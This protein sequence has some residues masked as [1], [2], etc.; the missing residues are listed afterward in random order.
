MSMTIERH[1]SRPRMSQ[2]VIHNG[3]VHLAGQ[4][5][6]D[7]TA[8]VA[9]QTR[10]TL[11]EIDRL[12][13]LAGTDK[14]KLITALVWLADMRDYD[15]MNEVWDAWTA[16]GCA[17]ARACTEAKLAPGWIVEIMVTAAVE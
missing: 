17:P 2:V 12:L 10:Q 5:G 8:S 9:D 15:A 13:A 11:E 16:E 4:V 7:K 6:S 1:E 3:I 14:S